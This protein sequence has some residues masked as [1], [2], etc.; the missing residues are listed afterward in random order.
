[1]TQQKAADATSVKAETMETAFAAAV[2][3]KGYCRLAQLVRSIED[4]KS[5]QVLTE[6]VEDD[7]HYS[8]AVVARV[9]KQLGFPAISTEAVTKH[10][11]GNCRCLAR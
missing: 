7:L 5:R 10:R 3:D 11:R 2:V 4:E 6:K 1:M 9:L 8:G